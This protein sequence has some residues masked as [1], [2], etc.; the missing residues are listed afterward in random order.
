MDVQTYEYESGDVTIVVVTKFQ[1]DEHPNET[2]ADFMRRHANRVADA[3]SQ[4][5]PN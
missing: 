5:P 1:D 3:M 2:R 4:Y